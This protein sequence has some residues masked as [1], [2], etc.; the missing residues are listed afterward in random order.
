MI[1]DLGQVRR[2]LLGGQDVLMVHGVEVP[3]D[4]AGSFEIAAAFD[5][6]RKGVE[7]VDVGSEQGYDRTAVQPAREKRPQ[8]HVAHQALRHCSLQRLADQRDMPFHGSLD[9]DVVRHIV[10]RSGPDP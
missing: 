5:A 2:D 9:R 10:V 1:E 7:L 4:G 8:R 3:R 6:D